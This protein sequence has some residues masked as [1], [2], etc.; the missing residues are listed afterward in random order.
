MKS[1]RFLIPT[2][3][4][5]LAGCAARRE[6]GSAVVIVSLES[7]GVVAIQVEVDDYHPKEIKWKVG[8]AP[9]P[10][11]GM[12]ETVVRDVVTGD[13]KRF[14][15]ATS[16]QQGA[17]LIQSEGKWQRLDKMFL[18]IRGPSKELLDRKPFTDLS[19]GPTSMSIDTSG[20]KRPQ[21]HP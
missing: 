8:Y 18:E 13:R 3:V 17:F 15:T 2:V 21:S 19:E 16:W 11:D 10:D 1:L 4:I 6:S 7:D 9:P 5:A 12:F 20:L 14:L